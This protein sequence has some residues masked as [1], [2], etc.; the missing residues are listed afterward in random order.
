MDTDHVS[1]SCDEV[2]TDEHVAAVLEA[3]GV[4]PVGTAVSGDSGVGSR[5]SEFLTHPAF[6]SYRTETEMMRYLRMLADKD[7]ALDRSMIPLGSCTM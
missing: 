1:V 6:N 7:I 2:T 3:F 4:A 5:T